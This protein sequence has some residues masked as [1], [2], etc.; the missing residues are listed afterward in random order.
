MPSP[1]KVA[2]TD[3]NQVITASSKANL[4]AGQQSQGMSTIGQDNPYGSLKYTTTIDPI[5]GLPKYQANMQYTP[6]QQA[7]FDQLQGQQTGAGSTALQNILNNFGQ[8][9]QDP[10]GKLLSN[11][12]GL[13]KDYMDAQ[14]PAWERF[15]AP[16][17]DQLRTQL[18]NQG[19]TEGSPAYQQQMDKLTQQQ[20]LT[21]NS[22]LANFQ[23]QAFQ[24]ANTTLNTPMDWEKQL[25]GMSQPGNIN[26]SLVNTPSGSV[27]PADVTGAYN[28]A[29]QAQEFNAQQ[30]NAY[31]NNIIGGGL[32]VGKAY[33]G[34]PAK[35]SSGS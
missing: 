35:G 5:T 9:T 34:M 33:L 17:R 27:N 20:L 4:T 29:Q 2:P 26:Q 8:Y 25:M 24:E 11:T 16:E 6:E 28:T 13:T 30:N 15:M 3:P 22:A 19:L 1:K 32:G 12:S 7:I 21:K 14:N 18:I 10:E 31:W 23:P